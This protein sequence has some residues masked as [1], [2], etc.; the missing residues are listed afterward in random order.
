MEKIQKDSAVQSSRQRNSSI[1]LLR[2]ILMLVIVSHHFAVHGGFSFPLSEISA[3]SLWVL[4]LSASGKMFLN[5]FVII[6]GYF[7]VNKNKYL[8]DLRQLIK[9][10]TQIAFYSIGIYLVFVLTGREIFS[11][12]TLIKSMIPICS[13]A[14]WFASTY[15]VLFLL[16]P[17]LNRLLLALDKSAFKCGL[18]IMLVCWSLVPTFASYSLQLNK[19]LWFICLYSIG[20]YIRIYGMNPHLGRKHY[21]AIGTV[22]FMLMFVASLL[23]RFL[24]TKWDFLLSYADHLYMM[25]NSLPVIIIS[26]CIFMFFEKTK[27]SY[28]GVINI[29]A[30]AT[31][32]VYLIHENYFV[33]SFLWID[34]F[35]NAEFQNSRYLIPYT[36]AVVLAVF[37]ICT[38]IELIRKQVLEK[39][40]MA[41]ADRY[42]ERIVSP[43]KKLILK[44][45]DAFW[46][47]D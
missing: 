7:L 45:G 8:F 34:L 27:L 3:S 42:I 9:L 4:L 38:T 12:K 15:F 36:I 28:N 25:E 39:P 19:L 6:S 13:S 33:R 23:I 2:I 17:F 31:F 29:I 22:T 26:I 43:A 40:F 35:R 37:A 18:I 14:W 44:I 24:C 32:G 30:S 5:V 47:R 46:G 1:E 11:A 21:V 10:W 20:A 16:H 41:F